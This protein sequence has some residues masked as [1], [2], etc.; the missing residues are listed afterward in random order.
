VNRAHWFWSYADALERYGPPDEIMP[1]EPGRVD[2]AYRDGNDQVRLQFYDGR[3][4]VV[5]R[6][7][8]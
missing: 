1:I 3:L 5:N 6:Y 4:L 7:R 8:Q 2:F